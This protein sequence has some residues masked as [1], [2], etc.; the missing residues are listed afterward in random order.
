VRR[1]AKTVEIADADRLDPLVTK[2]A[3]Q[4]ADKIFVE[5]RASTLPSAATR[6]GT[7]KRKW[8]GTKGFGKSRFKSY[9][10]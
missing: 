9:S 3:N 1:I 8:R 5:R 2:L 10:S 7:S 6:S 4:A